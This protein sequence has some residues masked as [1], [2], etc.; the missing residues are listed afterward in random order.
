MKYFKRLFRNLIF[1]NDKE[2][3][4]LINSLLI[5]SFLNEYERMKQK[6]KKEKDNTH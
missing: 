2:F 1:K 6:K 4:F 3:C 5:K